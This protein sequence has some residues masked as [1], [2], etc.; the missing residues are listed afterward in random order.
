[1]K[2]ARL[3]VECALVVA[4]LF[5]AA[6]AAGG[7]PD[8]AARLSILEGRVTAVG[9]APGEGGLTVV[10]V[11]L[12]NAEGTATVLLAPAS[13]LEEAGFDVVVGDLL[14]LRVFA[15]E[16]DRPLRAH[17]VFNQTRSAML[18]LR[19]L[20]ED[21]LWNDAGRWQGGRG[22]RGAGA[23][24]HGKGPGGPGGRAPGGGSGH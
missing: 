18:R 8:D 19:T 21:P 3:T 7:P 2:P 14:K 15:A 1:M 20:H 24:P 17:K 23:G 9:E 22:G 6:H 11:D 13:A 5:P 16:G 4:L 12:A 10:S